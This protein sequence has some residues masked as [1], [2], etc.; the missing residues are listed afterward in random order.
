MRVPHNPHG[1]HKTTY[2]RSHTLCLASSDSSLPTAAF[3]FQRLWV[4]L[5]QCEMWWF[6][7]KANATLKINTSNVMFT[8]HQKVISRHALAFLHSLSS[9]KAVAVS[10]CSAPS[11]GDCRHSGNVHRQCFKKRKRKLRKC[12]W[13]V[14]KLAV[15]VKPRKKSVDKRLQISCS[16]DH[17]L[18]S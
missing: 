13:K 11:L 5:W 10:S 7:K 1:A 12:I 17:D 18:G 2:I 4:L 14:E 15:V 8:H 3:F 6:G 16:G 9:S